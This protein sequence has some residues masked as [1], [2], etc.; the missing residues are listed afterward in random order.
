[1]IVYSHLNPCRAGVCAD[2]ME[3]RWSAHRYYVDPGCCAGDPEGRAEALHF[4]KAT[5]DDD[6]AANYAA[7]VAYQLKLDRYSRGEIAAHELSAPPPAHAGDDHW[8]QHYQGPLDVVAFVS[9][10]QPVYDVAC[11]LLAQLDTSVSIDLL[12]AGIRSPHHVYLRR[13]LISALQSLG[14]RGTQIARVLGLSTTAVSKVAVS[15][16]LE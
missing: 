14:F 2:P 7:H 15:L 12:R 5:P 11:R 9:P 10:R 16:R 13:E 1:V 8:H 4:F 3:Y 6:G